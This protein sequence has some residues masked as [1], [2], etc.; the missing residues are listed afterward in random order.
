VAFGA[1]IHRVPGAAPRF[2][3]LLVAPQGEAFV[4]LRG[5]RHVLGARALEDV[6][7]VVRIVEFGAEHG[8]EIE[9][10]E[11]SAVIAV[12]EFAGGGIRLVERVPIPLGVHGLALGV[13]G[14]VRRHRVDA[15]VDE[16]A[17]LGIGVPGR[18]GPL[19]EGFPGGLITILAE[20]A[21]AGGKRER[22]GRAGTEKVTTSHGFA[23]LWYQVGERCVS[24]RRT[25]RRTFHWLGSFGTMAAEPFDISPRPRRESALPRPAAA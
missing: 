20:G 19:V 2:V 21:A 24:S 4:V 18:A 5:Q 22:S 9:V 25:S 7:P 10:G 3:G 1:D 17:E 11:A 23:W 16:D 13:D 15:P 6:G 14:S 8:G 12:V